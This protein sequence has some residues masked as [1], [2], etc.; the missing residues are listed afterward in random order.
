MIAFLAELPRIVAFRRMATCTIA[1]GDLAYH[2]CEPWPAVEGCP[3]YNVTV[4]CSHCPP[5]ED[6]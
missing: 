5:S 3:L 4:E 6:S 1:G 2:R